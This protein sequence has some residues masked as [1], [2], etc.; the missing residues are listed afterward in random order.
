MIDLND[1]PIDV[2]G[3]CLAPYLYIN[4]IINL[5]RSVNKDKEE[6][7]LPNL[8]LETSR[9]IKK[10]CTYID[11]NNITVR[12]I[13]ISKA[14]YKDIIDL[15]DTSLEILRGKDLILKE[16]QMLEPGPTPP[17]PNIH[18]PFNRSLPP[19]EPPFEL[20]VEKI[21][22]FSKSKLS[23][24]IHF[25][26]IGSTFENISCLYIG[27]CINTLPIEH[28]CKQLEK[29]IDL[30]HL[31]LKDFNIKNQDECTKV[32]KLLNS[33]KK[34]ENLCIE[35]VYF[36][37]FFDD[38][39]I[40]HFHSILHNIKSLT[41]SNTDMKKNMT[42]LCKFIEASKTLLNLEISYHEKDDDVK[43]DD[44]VMNLKE[45][46]DSIDKND[47][48]LS[49]IVLKENPNYTK[50]SILHMFN[51][52]QYNKKI[53]TFVF[54]S[55]CVL[56]DDYIDCVKNF[57]EKNEYMTFLDL[58]GNHINDKMLETICEALKSNKT[59]KRLDL[60]HNEITNTS[61]IEEM[62]K[63]NK[64]LSHILLYHKTLM[65]NVDNIQHTLLKRS[66]L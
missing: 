17:N 53:N 45:L 21:S 65:Q 1:I 52:L 20:Y 3:A 38:E 39:Y 26:F 10:T 27:S 37:R 15:D 66:C 40:I 19:F 48:V 61:L 54:S 29:N 60:S 31:T 49:K 18:Y 14:C 56:Q 33:C 64:H 55:N 63:K 28:M 24:E 13:S 9:D 59:L 35:N 62:L 11:K 36:C 22:L 46:V 25:D 41:F 51:V 2:I 47:N 44:V 42:G 5:R 34:V 50:T 6:L 43:D 57:I 4:D 32:Q 30:K 23:Y 7:F 12:T 8:N 16:L 58:S